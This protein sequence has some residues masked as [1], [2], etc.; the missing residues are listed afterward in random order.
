M[1][2][3]LPELTMQVIAVLSDRY[4]EGKIDTLS[5]ITMIENQIRSFRQI[6]VILDTE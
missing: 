6:Q 5:V 4:R 1:P 2:L 3:P